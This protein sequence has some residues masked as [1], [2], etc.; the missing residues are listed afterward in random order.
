MIKP[1]LVCCDRDGTINKDENY[2]LGTKSD[3]RKQVEILPGVIDGI[4]SLKK[5][6]NLYFFIVTQQSGVAL[7]GKEFDRLTLGVMHEVNKYIIRLL[8][9]QGARV[10]GYFACPYIYNKKAGEYMLKGRKIN[11]DYVVDNNHDIK[12]RIGLIERAAKSIEASLDRCEVYVIGDRDTDVQ[13][14]LN[15]KGRGILVPG[16]KTEER[17]DI[18]KVEKLALENPG[19]VYIAR[20]FLD[21][22]DYI[23][24]N[25]KLK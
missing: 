11:P 19:R 24:K 16:N 23:K 2:F 15:A 8:R 7:I 25:V 22:S 17:A 14:G 10:E 1:I 18:G 12:P 13:M 20:D 5:T 21:A 6:K 3:W 4:K 9:S